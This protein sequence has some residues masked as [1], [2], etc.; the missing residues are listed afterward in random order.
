[1]QIFSPTEGVEGAAEGHIDL[2]PSNARHINC[3][4]Q[5]KNKGGDVLERDFSSPAAFHLGPGRY[6]AGRGICPEGRLAPLDVDHL[7]L[8]D[9]CDEGD[10]AV[11]AHRAEPFVMEKKNAEVALRIDGFGQ[12]AAVHIGMPPGLPDQGRA[13]MLG[14]LLGITALLPDG[15]PWKRGEAVP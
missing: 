13:Q 11:A 4:I 3:P 15:P 7:R 1:M 6:Q 2:D 8:Y 9:D 10:D 12:D 5:S 14:V